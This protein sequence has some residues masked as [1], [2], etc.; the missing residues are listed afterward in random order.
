MKQLPIIKDVVMVGGGHTHALVIRR[1]AM[2]PVAGVR[3][4]LVSR[5]VMTPYS[6]MLPAM[7]AG[8]YTEIETHIDLARLCRWA[9]VRFIEA[10]VTGIDLQQN[11]LALTP[12][13]PDFRQEQLPRPP[14]GFDV[15]SI[16]TGST[17]EL[18]SVP[19]ALEH[20]IPVKPVNRFNRHWQELLSRL[21]NQP[22]VDLDIG[23]VGAGVGGFELLMSIE[24]VI[25]QLGLA[26]SSD[27]SSARSGQA[28]R[29][30]WIVRGQQPLSRQPTRVQ[31]SALRECAARNI[32]VHTQFGVS[33][34]TQHGIHSE[35][36]R[37]IKLDET[38]WCTA[39]AA[40]PWPRESGLAVEKGGFIAIN[41]HL[42]STS[43]AHVFACGDVASMVGKTTPKSGVFAVR[44]APVLL[45]NLERL[46]RHKPLKR[47]AAQKQTLSLI[48]LGDRS[49]IASRNGLSFKAAWAWHW[50]DLVDQAFMNRFTNLPERK[51][52]PLTV[53]DVDPVLYEPIG[54]VEHQS[55]S[56]ED[57]HQI[58][59]SR[60]APGARIFCGGC[61]AKVGAQ[62]LSRVLSQLQPVHR[63]EVVSGLKLS[64][65]AAV[66]DIG[67]RLMAQTVDQFRAMLDD[68]W[69]F[70]RISAL[71]ALSDLFAS[72]ADPL[73]A[74]ALITLPF[75][76]EPVQERDLHQLI[77]GAVLELNRAGCT[78]AG[79][80]TSIG[81][82]LMLGFS[83][84]GLLPTANIVSGATAVADDV[85]VL[86]KPLGIGVVLAA[87]MRQQAEGLHVRE[88]VRLMLQ[89]NQV[90][91]KVFRETA[92]R[93]V[94]DVTGFGLLGHLLNL[95]DRLGVD[96]SIDLSS[97]P[98][99][100]SALRYSENGIRSSLYPQNAAYLER[101]QAGSL[102]ALQSRIPLL[103]DPQTNGGLLAVV[104]REQA[105]ECLS[106]F[107]ELEREAVIIGSIG[108]TATDPVV[109][110]QDR[111]Q[112]ERD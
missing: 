102:G 6:G 34:V 88:A 36:G 89:S 16:N 98:V 5:D 29:L 62:V 58:A 109:W 57:A 33:T 14:L 107:Q 85:I 8:H 27:N 67:G 105:A 38:L 77:A 47:F 91:A 30:H 81:P 11:Q 56:P 97:V 96:A 21:T 64:E 37:E 69:L 59:D 93:A 72:D 20:V 82:E 26:Y 103:L 19:G 17:P 66:L 83:V 110:L 53:D 7:V 52:S 94:T 2:K 13:E 76:E 25:R 87:Y 32:T 22:D 60:S 78:L 40:P 12:A 18:A 43:H 74:L 46:V 90:A 108:N 63:A 49:V 104:P 48:S 112:I 95:L 92:A 15:V 106:R 45:E 84:N 50:K 41:E 23:I 4:T 31:R 99:L 1:W 3:M 42:Q 100:D 80:H 51:M 101:S 61:G 9:G 54:V 71:H 75:A 65:D 44:Q 86:T 24:Y 35:D 55:H 111:L 79:G 39:A 28:V 70:G 73:S 68:P 10:S